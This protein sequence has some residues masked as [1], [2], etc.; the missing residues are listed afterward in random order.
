[1]SDLEAHPTRTE[2]IELMLVMTF[3]TVCVCVAYA[4]VN[5]L[6]SQRQQMLHLNQKRLFA[7]WNFETLWILITCN[8][9]IPNK[10]NLRM[11]P[12]SNLA[13]SDFQDSPPWLRTIVLVVTEIVN[14]S[15]L[16]GCVKW[17][18]VRKP[19]FIMIC[20][21]SNHNKDPLLQTSQFFLMSPVETYSQKPVF[22][23]D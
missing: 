7:R 23:T 17:E 6:S 3:F 20:R 16:Q 19:S 18:M 12:R 9:R 22:S 15:V 5:S 2:L 11:D 8:F 14:G 4:C 10:S 1:M 13:A 21:F